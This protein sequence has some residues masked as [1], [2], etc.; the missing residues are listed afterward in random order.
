ME[1]TRIDRQNNFGT[2]DGIT[3]SNIGKHNVNQHVDCKRLERNALQHWHA[4][5]IECDRSKFDQS[6]NQLGI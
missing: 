3:D 4:S 1:R 6:T 2:S 5:N